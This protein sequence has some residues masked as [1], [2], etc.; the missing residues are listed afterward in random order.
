M[1]PSA[2]SF[3]PAVRGFRLRLY[4]TH[5]SR[6]P[7]GTAGKAWTV[8]KCAEKIIIGEL[9]ENFWLISA[10]RAITHPVQV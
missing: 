8:K 3:A 6:I 4:W 10:V 5:E 9:S 7:R 2:D 1:N